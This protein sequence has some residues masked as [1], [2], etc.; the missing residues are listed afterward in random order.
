MALLI[1]GLSSPGY[2]VSKTFPKAKYQN[3]SWSSKDTKDFGGTTAKAGESQPKLLV[4]KGF[5]AEKTKER[6]TKG[7]CF[8]CDDVF[9]PGNK[10][11]G[12]LFRSTADETY[13]W[14]IDEEE[15][16]SKNEPNI[17]EMKERIEISLNAS[18]VQVSPNTIRTFL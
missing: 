18:K 11:K 8:N 6:T 7:L 1:E 5:S 10:C 14:E 4:F 13:F 17:I 15:E 12:K 3:S 16:T 9:T 2:G